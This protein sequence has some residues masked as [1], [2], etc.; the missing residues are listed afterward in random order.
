[1]FFH[2]LKALQSPIAAIAA[3]SVLLPGVFPSHHFLPN[4]YMIAFKIHLLIG[5]LAYSLFSIAAL[6]ALLMDFIEKRL[7]SKM[8]TILRNMPPLLTMETLLFRIIGA[9]FILL[10]LTLFSGVLYSEE[11]FGKPFE[12]S[13]KT[14]FAFISWAIFAVLLGGRH[15]YGWRGRIAVRST[16]TGFV[17]LLLAYIGSKFVLEV[18]LKR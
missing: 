14:L 11:L 1:S 12:F 13:H 15:L 7:H 2:N 6:Q 9:G 3:I 10:T 18:I 5:L 4:A 8:P 17:M 16:M